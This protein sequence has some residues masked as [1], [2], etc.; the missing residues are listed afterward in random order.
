[1]PWLIVI[2]PGDVTVMIVLLLSGSRV[3]ATAGGRS[4]FR[5]VL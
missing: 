4:E 3:L 5:V 1:M 2:M